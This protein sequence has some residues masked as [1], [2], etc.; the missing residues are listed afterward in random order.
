M[1]GARAGTTERFEGPVVSIGRHPT[2]DFRFDPHGDLDVSARHAELRR[3][4]DG[5]WTLHDLGS[6]NG[7]FVNDERVTSDRRVDVGDRIAF[8]VHGPIVEVL[9]PRESTDVRIAAAVKSQTALL[10]IV[11]G[12]LVVV[13]A[14][15]ALVWQRQ[16]AARARALAAP[17]AS[18]P[19]APSVPAGGIDLT[20]IHARNDAAVAMVASD[21]D[22]NF[23]AGTAFGVDT[24]G[25]LLTNRHVVTTAA[26]IRRGASA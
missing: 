11:V 13:A 9:P 22:G 5:T 3:A 16:A 8:G 4:G 10:R 12:A 19:S 14:T 26:D 23:L 2:N 6:T 21:L 18:S 17:V 7:T 20:G 1:R 15:G 25:M 24:S